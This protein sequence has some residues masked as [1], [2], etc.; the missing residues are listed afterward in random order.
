[1]NKRPIGLTSICTNS[2][3]AILKWRVWHAF[4]KDCNSIV[5]HV[6]RTRFLYFQKVFI[7]NFLRR[8]K[9][10]HCSSCRA[11]MLP[12]CC[13]WCELRVGAPLFL[14]NVTANQ[15]PLVLV[16]FMPH[17]HSFELHKSFLSVDI[18]VMGLTLIAMVTISS[19]KPYL[20]YC[21]F[22]LS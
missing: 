6:I 8:R 12:R 19:Q 11:S 21:F 14:L 4:D 3:H 2:L 20:H 7:C 16:A 15:T 10:V 18:M 13:F 9:T 1:M 5:R 22:Y 17:S